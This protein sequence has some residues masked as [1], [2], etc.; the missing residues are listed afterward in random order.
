MVNKKIHENIVN[1]G[2]ELGFPTSSWSA[3]WL[4]CN[5]IVIAKKDPAEI[6]YS[7]YDDCVTCEECLS[8]LEKRKGGVICRHR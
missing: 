6:F 5:Y 7:P 1:C 8:L 3:V 2:A 4:L